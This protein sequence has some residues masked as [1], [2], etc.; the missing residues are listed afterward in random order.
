MDAIFCGKGRWETSWERRQQ[1][2]IS[3]KELA[4]KIRIDEALMS[5]ILKCAFEEFTAD[6]LV[7][8]LSVLLPK[9]DIRL[10]VA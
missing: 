4:Q 5:N 8:Y 7:R 9:A 1:K 2:L 10:L 3:Q 6:R